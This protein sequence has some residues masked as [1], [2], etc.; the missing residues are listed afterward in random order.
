MRNDAYLISIEINAR[1]IN[2]QENIL[3]RIFFA[4]GLNYLRCVCTQTAAVCKVNLFFSIAN[5][6]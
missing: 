3:L 4:N 5:V 6:L 1:L 2:M